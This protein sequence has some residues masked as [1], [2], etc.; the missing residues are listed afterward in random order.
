MVVDGV[1]RSMFSIIDPQS[2][3]SGLGWHVAPTENMSIFIDFL[4]NSS[5]TKLRP[6][7]DRLVRE[8]R[9]SAQ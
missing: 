9:V 7:L 6:L 1:V 5:V 2:V 4:S 3:L 8:T